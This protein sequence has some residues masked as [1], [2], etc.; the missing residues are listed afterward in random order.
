AKLL[1]KQSDG[2]LRKHFDHHV[3]LKKGVCTDE[4]FYQIKQESMVLL[5]NLTAYPDFS[6]HL[7]ACLRMPEPRY[8]DQQWLV[9]QSVFKLLMLLA[10]QMNLEF[11]DKHTY[12]FTAASQMALQAMGEIDAPSDLAL[13]LDH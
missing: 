1:L 12:D 2:G 5:D 9:L 11:N 13:Y 10:A 6:F 8:E 3:G 4:L 7:N